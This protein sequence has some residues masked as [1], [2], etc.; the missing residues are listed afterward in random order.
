MYI[1]DAV[2]SSLSV[3]SHRHTHVNDSSQM[4]IDVKTSWSALVYSLDAAHDDISIDMHL[5]TQCPALGFYWNMVAKELN[6]TF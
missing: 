2:C 3:F 6:R 5:H 1:L 4:Y